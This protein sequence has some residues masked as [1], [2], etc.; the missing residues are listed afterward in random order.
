[1]LTESRVTRWQGLIWILSLVVIVSGAAQADP[2]GTNFTYQGYIQD[3]GAPANGDFDFEFNVFDGPDPA[4]AVLLGTDVRCAV[5]ISNGLFTTDLDVGAIFAGDTLWLEVGVVEAG[6]CDSSTVFTRLSPLQP[7]T[8]TP[9]AL[10][11]L[12][13]NQGPPGPAGPTGPIG[14]PGP[15]GEDANSP[16]LPN[17]SG[18]HYTGG[19]VGIGTPSP[20]ERLD[21]A[22]NIELT[23]KLQGSSCTASGEDA[24]ALGGGNT[25]SGLF[26]V[27][28]G[29]T[30]EASGPRATALGNLTN[31]TGASSVAMGFFTEAQSFASLVLGRHNLVS[32]SPVS[33]LATDPALVI[34]NGP[35]SSSRSNAMTVF[36]NG[37]VTIAG[38]LTQSSDAR[39]KTSIQPIESALDRILSLRGVSFRWS[40][41]APP[42]SN[43]QVGLI[44]QEVEKAFP[45]LVTADIAGFKSVN[46]A[47]MVAP[48]LEALKEQQE[49][50][51]RLRSH[52]CASDAP[53]DFCG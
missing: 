2:L 10:F 32:G 9:Y 45:E 1:M 19:N 8:A 46:Y 27:A 14:P 34:G 37:N 31:A 20:D 22:G 39:L 26:S 48:L 21:V 36:K 38:S 43:Q 41:D 15:P 6:P 13:G 12:D 25:A 53:G 52:I 40:M 49:Q 5:N 18:I 35:S 4:Q 3:G 44:A 23:G 50:I 42:S 47:G 11:A 16:W 33:W 17:P 24:V 29:Q 7:L 28:L 30:T 51:D